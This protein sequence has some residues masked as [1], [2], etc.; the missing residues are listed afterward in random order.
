MST[1][2]HAIHVTDHAIV[3]YLERVKLI[4][5]DI[6]R[7]EIA[8]PV[9][10]LAADFGAPVVILRTGH[11]VVVRDGCVPTILEKPKRRRQR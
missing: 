1:L 7:Q 2:P 3:R 4:D 5:M 6:I 11:R 10:Q 8:S 9:V